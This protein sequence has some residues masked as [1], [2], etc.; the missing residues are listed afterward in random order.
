MVLLLVLL[1]LPLLSGLWWVLPAAKSVGAADAAIS[2]LRRTRPHRR[3]I[4]CVKIVALNLL[5]TRLP[6]NEVLFIACR[7]RSRSAG[8]RHVHEGTMR[9]QVRHVPSLP[10]L[11]GGRR[12]SARVLTKTAKITATALKFR[13]LCQIC[14][15]LRLP[16]LHLRLPHKSHSKERYNYENQEHCQ[17]RFLLAWSVQRL[18][19]TML[20]PH[21]RASNRHRGQARMRRKRFSC[22][23]L[24][25]RQ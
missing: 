7:A 10:G 6:P 15:T 4:K 5:C 16:S 13:L 19:K 9:T 3:I 21:T 8:V 25:R 22:T 23:A 20:H 11:K 1:L 24:D 2:T 14:S 12:G 18:P 17:R